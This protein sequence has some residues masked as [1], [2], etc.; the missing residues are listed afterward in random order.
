[1]Q[2]ELDVVIKDGKIILVEIKSSAGKNDIYIFL[3]K[4]SFFENFSKSKVSKMVF[5]T[6]SL[7]YIAKETA[8]KLNIKLCD[9]TE[10]IPKII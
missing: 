3:K 9:S 2:V 6:P 5:I 7:D 4:R 8:K 1:E 10:K